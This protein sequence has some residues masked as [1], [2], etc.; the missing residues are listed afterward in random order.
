MKRLFLLCFAL[1]AITAMAQSTLKQLFDD[2]E[3]TDGDTFYHATLNGNFVNMRGGT[4]HEG[5]YAFGLQCTDA[6]ALSFTLR[7]GYWSDE[8]EGEGDLSLPCPQG[9]AVKV[10][11]FDNNQYL[12]VNDKQ[13]N[14]VYSLRQMK[15]G[16]SAYKLIASDIV[17][18]FVG[19]YK[20]QYSDLDQCP[21]GAA[22]T[23]TPDRIDLGRYARGS[24][25][26][27]EAFETPTNVFKLSNGKYVKLR[28]AGKSTD[29]RYGV[30]VYE[31]TFD[32]ESEIYG[33]DRLLLVL[34]RVPGNACRWPET[35]KQ[36]LLPAQI[37]NHPRTEMQVM[38]NEIFARYGYRFKNNELANYFNSE[39]W[40]KPGADN[41][42]HLSDIESI[43]VSLIRT[44]ETN[45]GIYLPEL[46]EDA[47]APGI[48][49]YDANLYRTD[50]WDTRHTMVAHSE[51]HE[52][53]ITPDLVTPYN[54]KTSQSQHVTFEWCKAEGNNFKVGLSHLKQPGKSEL[55]HVVIRQNG[56]D[57]AFPM[58]K[59]GGEDPLPEVTIHIK[60][61][62]LW[63]EL[64]T[65]AGKK[66]YY[67]Y[68]VDTHVLARSNSN[69]YQNRVAPADAD[70]TWRQIVSAQLSPKAY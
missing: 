23:I 57:L 53:E 25:E 5:G 63:L 58:I 27:M 26:V 34:E 47:F 60:D 55:K 64:K 32:T 44:I 10:R 31:Q 39:P 8:M 48:G 40:Y 54:V 3:W 1:T 6:N 22:C 17:R 65:L 62:Y 35:S 4:L 42:V 51:F 67:F 56:S 7:T 21:V 46:D 68:N 24:F 20:V 33:G 29:V 43:N 14:A 12:L 13:G 70:K 16:E 66:Y 9:S 11:T 61:N 41:N 49:N 45:K 37:T 18:T 15:Q 28:I 36:V 30:S 38:R 69:A 59:I 19:N 52:V 2:T 50:P